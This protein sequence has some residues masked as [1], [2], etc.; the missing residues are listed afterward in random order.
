[1][2]KPSSELPPEETWVHFLDGYIDNVEK[3]ILETEYDNLFLIRSPPPEIGKRF[4][5]TKRHE[6]WASALKRS[7]VA[8]QELT[9]L[10]FEW[11]IID[12]QSGISMNSVNHM[13]LADNSLLVL[14]PANY[15]VDATFEF[16]REM[17][18][19]LQ[20]TVQTRN[21]FYV[22]NQVPQ[23]QNDYEKKLLDKFL[24]IWD[25]FFIKMGVRPTIRIPYVHSVS[26]ELLGRNAGIFPHIKE[27]YAGI[28]EIANKIIQNMQR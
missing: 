4:L 17:I 7:I 1:M 27:F 20:A 8:Q 19:I 10:G 15:G 16:L 5:S 11:I 26:I 24:N 6:W 13:A 2:S 21:D 25:D 14:R 9:K 22:W 18:S 12:N 28:E 23:P 3:I